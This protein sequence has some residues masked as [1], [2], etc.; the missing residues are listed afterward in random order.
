MDF[1][2]ARGMTKKKLERQKE[3]ARLLGAGVCRQD[4]LHLH[5]DKEFPLYTIPGARSRIV[6]ARNPLP[7]LRFPPV[8]NENK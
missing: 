7:G 5:A 3:E 2:L 1:S 4:R 6:T 8:V